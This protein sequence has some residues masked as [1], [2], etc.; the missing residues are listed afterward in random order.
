MKIRKYGAASVPLPAAHCQPPLL[1]ARSASASWRSNQLSPVLPVDVE[2]LGQERR[3]DHP[4]AVV[5]P[6]RRRELAHRGVDEGVT[7]RAALP[8]LEPGGVLLPRH[9]VELGTEAFARRRA[10]SGRGRGGRTRARR[11]RATNLRMFSR[12]AG[13]ASRRASS[14]AA[15]IVRGETVPK[16]RCGERRDVPGT[17]RPVAVI[18]VAGGRTREEA[19]DEVRGLGL[20]ALRRGR[21][22][23]QVAP[24]AHPRR[25]ARPR[26]PVSRATAGEGQGS[27]LLGRHPLARE[28]RV[29]GVRVAG[30]GRDD[31]GLDEERVGEEP[32][33]PARRLDRRGGFAVA[34]LGVRA[35]LGVGVDGVG[36]GLAQERRAGPASAG[37]RRRIEP[38]GETGERAARAS[39]LSRRKRKR[40]GPTLGS[41]P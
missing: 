14:A 39:R 28:R 29:D 12:T 17:V 31:V 20:A 37:P 13:G 22:R 25:G 11:A 40:A 35:D 41:L 33:V 30:V 2:V 9:P 23:R 15:R 26:A 18:G 5:H 24:G 4:R 32:E 7:R 36:A 38:A 3:R 21:V 8:R 6:V 1:L 16:W 27:A 19:P 34:P 10:E